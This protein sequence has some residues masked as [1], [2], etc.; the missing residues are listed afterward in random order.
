MTIR[1]GQHMGGI[2]DDLTS[3]PGQLATQAAQQLTSAASGAATQAAQ[4]A[5]QVASSVANKAISNAVAQGQAAIDQSSTKIIRN[6]MVAILLTAAIIGGGV[7][8]WRYA[9]K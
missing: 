7:V 4:A 6:A 5:G 2:L 8:A 9:N 1:T 3:I